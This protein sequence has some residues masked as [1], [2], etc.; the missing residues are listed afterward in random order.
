MSE[1]TR[2][3]VVSL[4]SNIAAE[5]TTNYVTFIST[6]FDK[7]NSA[8]QLYVRFHA[9]LLFFQD[10]LTH[11]AC[12]DVKFRI[13]CGNQTSTFV[14]NPVVPAAT[15]APD[16]G[17][18]PLLPFDGHALFSN[19]GSGTHTITVDCRPELD[20]YVGIYEGS[21]PNNYF[22]FLIIEELTP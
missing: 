15:G 11:A 20:Q 4:S 16:E 2:K 10:L 8:T 14:I 22:M 18:T 9:N 12:K 21:E 17:A 13:T 3:K 5:N 19:I 6:T 7:S 1:I